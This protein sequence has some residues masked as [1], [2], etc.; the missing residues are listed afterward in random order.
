MKKKK[1]KEDSTKFLEKLEDS[2]EKAIKKA[3]IEASIDLKKEFDFY[4]RSKNVIVDSLN[5]FENIK[6]KKKCF[7]KDQSISFEINGMMILFQKSAFTSKDIP[8]LGADTLLAQKIVYQNINY[9]LPNT[10]LSVRK[11]KY[12]L[13]KRD[14]IKGIEKLE[15]D[16]ERHIMIALNLNIYGIEDFEKIENNIIAIPSTGLKDVLFVLPKDDLPII[17][18]KEIKTEKQKENQ[19]GILDNEKKVYASLIDLSKEN[20]SKHRYKWNRNENYLEEESKVQ[21]TIAF[22]TEIIW[23]NNSNVIQINIENSIEEQGIVDEIKDL[24]K[25]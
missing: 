24:E 21:L 22:I 3:K 12:L 1:I 10:F 8:H 4:I 19:L 17:K 5:E 25:M 9:Y 23:K 11:R 7:S 13:R 16:V 2:I 15:F 14:L 20:N 18:Y 6:N